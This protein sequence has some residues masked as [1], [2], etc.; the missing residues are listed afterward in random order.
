MI[1]W[2]QAIVLGVVQGLTEF[3]PVS[4]TAHVLIVSKIAGWQDPGAAFTAVTQIGTETAVLVYFRNEIVHIIRCLIN[5]FRHSRYRGTQDSQLAWAVVWGSMPIAVVGFALRHVIEGQARNLYL[6]ASMLILFGVVLIAVERVEVSVR[7]TSILTF[8][9]GIAMGLAQ[10]LALIPGVSRSG[11]TISAG[12]FAGL[13]RRAAT[14]YA[15]LLAVPAVMGSGFFEA[16]QIGSGPVAWGPTILATLTA[17]VIGFFVIS[18]LLNYLAHRSFIAFGIY[19]IVLGF[20]LLGLL[21]TGM[22]AA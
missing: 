11:A 12:I 9:T 7:R 14:R 20:V 13:E 22:V 6:V 16:L 1:D 21:A 17:S 2:F 3:L 10:T 19:R 8:R 18:G 15:F 5:W 4:S